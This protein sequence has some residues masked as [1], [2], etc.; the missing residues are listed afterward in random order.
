VAVANKETDYV[1]EDIVQLTI[2]MDIVWKSLERKKTEIALQNS[3]EKFRKT[4]Y[5]S[6][7]GIT[8]TR[9][10][11]GKFISLNPGYTDIFGYTE[12]DLLGKRSI[13]FNIWLD[14]DERKEWVEKLLK[15]G[16]L[17]NYESKFKAKS[18]KILYC[19]LSATL[20]ELNGEQCIL[21]QTIDIT[22]RKEA[23]EALLKKNKDLDYM[24]KFMVN[25]EVRMAEM[26]REI[27]EMLERL[28]EEKRYL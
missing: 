18:G 11:D 6:P 19:M 8:I 4:F 23:E 3:E 10:S 26:K 16:E 24:N 20:I 17:K 13:D 22:L 2:L 14:L 25:R 27:N 12:D 7:D 9:L 28:G 21:T 15:N 5:A 1:D